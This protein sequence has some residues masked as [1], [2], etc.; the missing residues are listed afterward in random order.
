MKLE[1]CAANIESVKN[2]NKGGANQIELCSSLSIEGITPSLGFIEKAIEISKIPINVLIRPRAGNFIYNKKEQEIILKDIEIIKKTGAKGIVIGFLDP[3][4]NIPVQFLKKCVL[5][6]KGLEICFHRAFD[7]LKNPFHS[8][9][10]LKKYNINSVLTTGGKENAEVGIPFLK[11]L[12]QLA[13]DKIT[14]MPG[15]GIGILNFKKFF[16]YFKIIHLSAIDKTSDLQP[17]FLSA[18]KI[19]SAKIIFAIVKELKR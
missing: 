12:N 10:I 3:K 14:I 4:G 19:S 7:L 18:D 8:L 9:E 17:D 11:K 6:A 1:I 2:A 5:K 16:P 15:S 13:N